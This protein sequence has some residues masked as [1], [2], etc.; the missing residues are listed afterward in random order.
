[1]PK[2]TPKGN[3]KRGALRGDSTNTSMRSGSAPTGQ[4]KRGAT[5][6]AGA[7]KKAPSG[8]RPNPAISN[9]SYGEVRTSTVPVKRED[10]GVR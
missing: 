2:G 5:K 1:M 4:P 7:E 10:D 6:V 3:D 9:L 8:V